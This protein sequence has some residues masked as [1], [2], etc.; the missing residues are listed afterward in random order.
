MAGDVANIK[1]CSPHIL[2]SGLIGTTTQS[3]TTHTI[4]RL[5]FI[6]K[7]HCR[8]YVSLQKDLI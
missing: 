2:R 4:Y 1:V 8:K 7:E 5:P 3:A 6:E